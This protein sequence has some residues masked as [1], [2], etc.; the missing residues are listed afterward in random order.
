MAIIQIVGKNKN[1][2]KVLD[3]TN[4]KKDAES[5]VSYWEQIMGRGWKISTKVIRK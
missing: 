3:E 5:Q 2:Q 4:N 1:Q